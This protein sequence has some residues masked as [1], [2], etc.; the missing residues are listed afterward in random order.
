MKWPWVSRVTYEYDLAFKE[1]YHQ[2]KHEEFMKRFD[3]LE[4]DRNYFRQAYYDLR[5]LAGEKHEQEQHYA[6]L[7]NGE[8]P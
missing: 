4:D 1:R 3:R 6:R 2:L 8:G 5:D 7:L